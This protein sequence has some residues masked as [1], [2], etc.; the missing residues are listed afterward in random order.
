MATCN[1]YSIK[2]SRLKACRSIT[3]HDLG[4]HVKAMSKNTGETKLDTYIRIGSN[5]QECWPRLNFLRGK[6]ALY[7]NFSTTDY[8][9][10]AF[11][12]NLSLVFI[13]LF[14]FYPFTILQ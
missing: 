7:T 14:T 13:T 3:S 8:I 5:K 12:L 9:V 10:F 11:P 1:G 4:S 2:S 6:G